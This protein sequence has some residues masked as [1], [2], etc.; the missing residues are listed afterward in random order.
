MRK[1]FNQR[2]VLC[3]LAAGA[4]AGVILASEDN[5]VRAA[6][7]TLET[8][9][10]GSHVAAAYGIKREGKR[11]HT[12]IDV[13][14]AVGTPIAVPA[15]ATVV[16]VSD[17]FRSEPRYGKAVV[18]KLD[19]GTQVWITHLDSYSVKAG[20]RLSAGDVF[21]TVGKTE[22]MKVP[23]IHIETWLDSGVNRQVDP[24]SVWPFLKG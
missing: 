7:P 6:E 19:D 2:A 3:L 4:I 18:L 8:F 5:A 22:Y 9:I 13:V 1:I 20:D 11:D 23:H 12:G 14:A 21:A 10:P 16:E 17:E 24:A 15:N